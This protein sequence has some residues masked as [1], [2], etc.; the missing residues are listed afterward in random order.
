MKVFSKKLRV[1]SL[2]IFLILFASSCGH[3]RAISD[4][5]KI[6]IR[7]VGTWEGEETDSQIKGL[8]KEWYQI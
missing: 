8:K 4:N 5:K 2:A 7:L 1:Y 6:D 3:Y